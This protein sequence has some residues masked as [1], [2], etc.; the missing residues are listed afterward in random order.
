MEGGKKGREKFRHVS[1][2]SLLAFIGSSSILGALLNNLWKLVS[3]TVVSYQS[4]LHQWKH[5]S[6]ESKDWWFIYL[7][8]RVSEGPASSWGGPEGI[9]S[10]AGLYMFMYASL[11]ISFV[12][13]NVGKQRANEIAF[14]H[15]AHLVF[16]QNQVLG[17]VVDFC[18]LRLPILKCDTVSPRPDQC[19]I[20]LCTAHAC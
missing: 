2:W 5:L 10:L 9:L 12:I 17:S 20:V 7:I 3:G 1:K 11:N 8:V 4:I 15:C 14:E 19:H 16:N 18:F 13:K 6:V